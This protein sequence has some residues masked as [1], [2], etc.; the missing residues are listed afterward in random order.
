MKIKRIISGLLMLALLFTA[1][2]ALGSCADGDGQ[3]SD[4][5][6]E[7][8]E[9][10]TQT[11]SAQDSGY[12][13]LT[14]NGKAL[15]DIAYQSK[16]IPP[17][18]MA[19]ND[20]RTIA[21]TLAAALNEKLEGAEF[22]VIKDTAI[23]S[24]EKKILAIGNVGDISKDIYKDVKIL[25]CV[26]GKNGDDLCI[27]GYT[28]AYVQRAADAIK[29]NV[30]VID[31][32]LLLST[33]A[34]GDIYRTKYHI[35]NMT[36]NG[37]SVSDYV[38]SYAKGNEAHAK[39]LQ[40]KLREESGYLMSA[41]E[42]SS[43]DMAIVLDNTLE[44]GYK[45]SVNGKKLVIAYAPEGTAWNI[46]SQYISNKISAVAIGDSFE[47]A[48]LAIE[49]SGGAG[50]KLLSFNVLNV[51]NKNGSPADRDDATA[52]LVLKHMPD[53]VCLQEFDVG[54]RNAENG[55]ISLIS[56]KYAE[57]SVNGVN[58]NEIWNP[59]FY[60]KDK[61]NVVE[62]GY[63]YFPSVVSSYEPSSYTG[64]DFGDGKTNSRFR[65]LVWAVLED[66]T[67]GTKYLVGS[68]H[69][70]FLEDTNALSGYQVAEANKI[71]EV[72]TA[73]AE[74]YEGAI[75]LVA[76]DLNSVRGQFGTGKL[77]S[78][79]FKDT[80]DVAMV[81]N[82]Y[83]TSNKNNAGPVKGYLTNAIDHVLTLNDLAVE[84]YFVLTDSELLPISDHMPTIVQFSAG[85]GAQ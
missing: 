70:S 1:A 14:E 45:I 23:D 25:D 34:L 64:Y 10:E 15:Y 50:R 56:E 24:G 11:D 40:N 39:E 19:V 7:S 49:N 82:D 27:A 5:V 74:Q 66:K 13:A 81:R 4:S 63:V 9:S 8:Q 62:S 46:I 83:G 2:A 78:N 59:I 41:K 47:L 21:N 53:F 71:T 77:M 51:W 73:K 37:A 30:K 68:T 43:S 44:E 65:S 76:G 42:G 22:D 18:T 52:A 61:Y 85:S 75:T 17:D 84:S 69:L 58:P 6:N 20:Y 33:E 48:S 35:G 31:G 36:L 38:I 80:Y 60:L 26:M 72:M 79:G 32:E 29:K 55:F 28:K 54:Y 12:I 3:T 67:D 16:N 57:V